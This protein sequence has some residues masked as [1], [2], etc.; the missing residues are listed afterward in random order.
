M[1]WARMLDLPQT[2]ASEAGI[3]RNFTWLEERRLAR[4]ERHRRVRKVFL[5]QEDGSGKKFRRATGADRGYFK[6]PY[7]YFTQ[8]W[9]G[10]LALA[11]KATLILCLAQAPT[12]VLPAEHAAGWY[13]ISA[14][15]LQRG[16]DEL[17][18][19][20]L[21]KVWSRAKKAPRTRFGYTVENH[22]ALQGP[23]ARAPIGSSAESQVPA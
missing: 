2:T 20:G 9:H 12:F 23:F 7:E 19:L 10:E 22:Y 5:L 3:S 1:A 17:R 4:S 6:V 16:L 14:D 15:T 13:G 11:G 8:R 18:D 21:I